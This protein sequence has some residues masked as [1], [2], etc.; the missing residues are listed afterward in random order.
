MPECITFNIHLA[1]DCCKL[2]CALRNPNYI[3]D[4]ILVLP[5]LQAA[6]VPS[7]WVTNDLFLA[8][9]GATQAVPGPLFTFSAFLGMVMQSTPNGW[10]SVVICVVAIFAPSFLLVAGTLPF[11][12]VLRGGVRIKA[13]L[14]GVNA[15]VVGILLATLYDPVWTSARVGRPSCLQWRTSPW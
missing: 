11:W 1:S 5:L 2:A 8:G 13:A 6:V 14:A 15:A 7:G 4:A 9:Y 12:E 10:S 3:P